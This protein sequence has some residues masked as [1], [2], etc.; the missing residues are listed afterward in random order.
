MSDIIHVKDYV[1]HKL[2]DMKAIELSQILGTSVCMVTNYKKH[3]Y[4]ASLEVAKKVYKAEGIV[5]HPF[6][7][8]SL[9][10]ELG[11]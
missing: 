1:L 7:E 9:K 11:E 10:Y 6:S 3:K 4:N 2:E 5:L 8:A